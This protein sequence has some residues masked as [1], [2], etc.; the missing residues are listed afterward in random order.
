MLRSKIVPLDKPLVHGTATQS[1]RN[2]TA[3][4][5]TSRASG[6]PRVASG[7]AI[8]RS[9]AVAFV[10]ALVAALSVWAA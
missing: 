9:S 3:E 5:H 1:T 10:P 4:P 7:S 8:E 2:S 6:V